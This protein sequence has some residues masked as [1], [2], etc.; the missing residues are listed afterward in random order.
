MI[1]TK[2]AVNSNSL[3]VDVGPIVTKYIDVFKNTSSFGFCP[4]IKSEIDTASHHQFV[5]DA[6]ANTLLH[7]VEDGLA[8]SQYSAESQSVD[9]ES[10]GFSARSVIQ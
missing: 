9:F 3:R 4:A 2:I 10:A 6:L 8:T 5:R 1:H 7:H